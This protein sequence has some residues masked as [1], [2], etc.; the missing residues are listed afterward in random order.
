MPSKGTTV[1]TIRLADDVVTMMEYEIALR[2][3]HSKRP[4]WDVS[5]FIREAIKELRRKRIAGRAPRG[6]LLREG[7]PEETA[8]T[9]PPS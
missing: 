1:R 2:N 4:P 3:A 9:I 5:A 8:A 6:Q 7:K